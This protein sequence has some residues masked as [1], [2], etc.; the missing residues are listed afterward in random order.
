M[1]GGVHQTDAY[2]APRPAVTTYLGRG[3]VANAVRHEAEQ[4]HWAELPRLQV[5]LL[6]GKHAPAAAEAHVGCNRRNVGCS[7]LQSAT[8]R[9]A[10]QQ[11]CTERGFLTLAGRSARSS[12]TPP[13]ATSA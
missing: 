3:G 9:H 13:Q 8:L 10:L 11:M 7:A 6:H 4:Q 1:N 12:Y 2:Q 5:E